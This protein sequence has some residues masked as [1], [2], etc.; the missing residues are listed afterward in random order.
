VARRAL[1]AALP[2]ALCG[3]LFVTFWTTSRFDRLMAYLQHLRR[4]PLSHAAFDQLDCG[5]K[6]VWTAHLFGETLKRLKLERSRAIE[7]QRIGAG[8]VTC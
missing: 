7:A 8:A 3:P 5:L 1:V 2:V 4:R 6:A